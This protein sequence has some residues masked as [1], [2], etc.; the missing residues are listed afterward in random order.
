MDKQNNIAKGLLGERL[1]SD[2]LLQ[3]NYKIIERNFHSHFGEIDIIA[4][5][6][7]TL[8]FVEVKTRTNIRF[9]LPV[10]AVTKRKIENIIK[11]G[12]YYSQK[13]PK[14]PKKLRIEVVSVDLSGS[15]PQLELTPVF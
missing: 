11:T 5:I 9:G 8:V 7:N 2:F 12:Q 13:N 1:A 15:I 3:K 4:T 10:E 14:L 6:D